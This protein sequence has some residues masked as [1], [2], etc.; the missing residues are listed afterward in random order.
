MIRILLIILLYF[1][2]I[3]AKNITPNEVYTQVKLISYEIHS[4]LKYY[5]IPHDHEGIKKRVA[6]TTKLKP[7][8]VWQKS[9]EIMVKI[10]LLRTSNNLPVIEPV[11]MAPVLNLNPDLV[12]EQT[13]RILTELKIFKDRLNIKYNKPKLETYTGKTPLD[14]FNGLSAVSAGL[15]ELNHGGVTPSYV[16]G[17]NMRVYYDLTQILKYLNIEDNTIPAKKNL[18]ATPTNTFNTGMLSLDKIKEL[19]INSGID[20]VD[21]SGFRKLKQ[22]PSEVFSITEMIISELQTIKAY[23]GIKSITPSAPFYKDKT[24]VEVDQLMSWNLRKLNLI[25]SL[26]IVRRYDAK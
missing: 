24:P 25:H 6:L 2:I 7:R 23:L 8:N 16:F 21:F 18:R 1:N 10:N 9:Y 13:Q 11:N 19:Q 26:N 20:F 3:N 22:T 15:D 17:E 5:N 12:Y 14:V 4:L